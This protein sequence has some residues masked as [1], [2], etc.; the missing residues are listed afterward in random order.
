MN[1]EELKR[2]ED[3]RYLY[4]YARMVCDPIEFLHRQQHLIYIICEHLLNPLKDYEKEL[5]EKKE[6]D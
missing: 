4:E 1:E 5:Q 3:L 2:L 6:D